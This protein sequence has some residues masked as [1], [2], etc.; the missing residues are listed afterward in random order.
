MSAANDQLFVDPLF[1][2][3]SMA[4]EAVQSQPAPTSDKNRIKDFNSTLILSI[5][6][7]AHDSSC[8]PPFNFKDEKDW[9]DERNTTV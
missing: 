6:E 7:W 3:V 9:R 8:P 5:A 2:M 4:G 1:S